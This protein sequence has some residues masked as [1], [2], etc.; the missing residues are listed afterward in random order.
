MVPT[1]KAECIQ[2]SLA[3]VLCPHFSHR[4]SVSALVALSNV[5]S[6]RFV[7]ECTRA[8]V[9]VNGRKCTLVSPSFS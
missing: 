2:R 7:L 3:S 5:S 4:N 9:C 8:H 6:Y 1:L